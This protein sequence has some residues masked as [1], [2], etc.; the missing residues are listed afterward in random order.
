MLNLDSWKD[1]LE[2]F[3]FPVLRCRKR[4]VAVTSIARLAKHQRLPMDTQQLIC[5]FAGCTNFNGM[6]TFPVS[7]LPPSSTQRSLTASAA[8]VAPLPVPS[9][10]WRAAAEELEDLERCGLKVCRPR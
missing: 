10:E 7:C 1:L 4:H 5:A 2:E 3:G 9:E 8:R 6:Y